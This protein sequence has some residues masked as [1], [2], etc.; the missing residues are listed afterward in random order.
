MTI[1][2]GQL[3]LFA[4]LIALTICGVPWPVEAGSPAL[5]L[6]QSSNVM[7]CMEQ[8]IR[9]EGKTK[10]GSC[11]SH[12]ANIAS[13]PPKQQNCMGI[14]KNCNR[15]CHKRDKICQRGCKEALMQCS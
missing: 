6:A 9:S 14:Y 1:H 2:R 10:K 3:M 12:C 13:R 15:N 7:K 5:E 4:G 8:C 11:K